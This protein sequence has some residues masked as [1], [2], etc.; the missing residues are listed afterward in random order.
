M[1]IPLQSIITLILDVVIFVFSGFPVRRAAKVLK[2]KTK[3]TKILLTI[4]IAGIILS[5]IDAFITTIGSLI[6]TI[7]LIGIYKI[8]FKLKWSK[9]SLLWL[10]QMIFI[11]ASRI[12]LELLLSV[13]F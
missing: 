11:V 3:F 13:L 12:I 9:A 1:Q 4:F 7:I 5:L 6:A 8:S 2:I 10:L